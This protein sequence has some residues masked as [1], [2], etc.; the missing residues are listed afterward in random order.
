VC[1]RKNPES[2]K[3]QVHFLTDLLRQFI[4]GI[5]VAWCKVYWIRLYP[6]SRRPKPPTFTTE[7]LL[8]YII[9]LVVS[10][11]EVSW[12]YELAIVVHLEP[13]PSNSL[14]RSHSVVSSHIFA[15]HLGKRI[16]HISP[17]FELRPYLRLKLLK[18]RFPKYL[19]QVIFMGF[20]KG[21]LLMTLWFSGLTRKGLIY[22]RHLD[23]WGWWSIPFSDWALHWIHGK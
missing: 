17:S 23:F 18:K 5:A 14:I 4:K 6:D 1:L 15:R 10:E 19:R 16:S 9:K 3:Y 22:L 11:D 13:R 7:G 21:D 8:N 12:W 2:R 20:A